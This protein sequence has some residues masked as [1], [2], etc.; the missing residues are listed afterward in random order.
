[1]RD[2]KGKPVRFIGTSTDI[3]ERKQAEEAL[4]Q[5]NARLDLAVRGSNV[6]IWEQELA[7]GT[8]AG[9]VHCTNI[10][11]QLGYPPPDGP[12]DFPTLV[13]P[14]DPSDLKRLEEGVLAYLAGKTPDYWVEFRARHRD[15]SWRWLL[16]RAIVVRDVRGRPIR[17]VDPGAKPIKEVLA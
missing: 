5:A 3:T 14:L 6:S 10:M 9:R 4:R 13:A 11:E 1:M 8:L 15:G 7:D 12:I 2:P 17:F 16:S